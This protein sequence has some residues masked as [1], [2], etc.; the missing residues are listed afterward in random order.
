MLDFAMPFPI[1]GWRGPVDTL[2]AVQALAAD[3]ARLAER[4][5]AGDG[6][7]FA[8]LYGRYERRA[9]N[10]TQ[11]AFVNVLRRLPKLEGRELAFG[12]YLFTSARHSCYDLIE[13]RRRRADRRASG[14]DQ[15]RAEGP[16]GRPGAQPPTQGRD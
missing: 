14:A 5:I 8:E 16:G 10:L 12:S 3:E 4:A 13:R 9:Y 7:A 15:R 6:N 11:D 1:A 2:A